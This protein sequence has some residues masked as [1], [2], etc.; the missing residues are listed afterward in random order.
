[1]LVTSQLPIQTTKI[2]D[3]LFDVHLCP[4]LWKRF[5]H[6]WKYLTVF[7]YLRHFCWLH[8]KMGPS[9]VRCNHTTW[10]LDDLWAASPWVQLVGLASPRF[11]VT[12]WNTGHIVELGQL[13]SL[14]SE[15]WLDIHSFTNL[16][17]AH[18]VVK[19]RAVNS[20]GKSNHV[21]TAACT[22]GT[23]P[24]PSL[25]RSTCWPPWAISVF[26]LHLLL[27]RILNI[28]PQVLCSQPLLKDSLSL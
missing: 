23:T 4:P 19:C 10:S 6:P 14:D 21:I 1:M 28:L 18:F 8:N 11:S 7:S 12:F 15:K 16:T 20:S 9:T 27:V 26:K 5:R 13:G 2:F 17:A 25:M 3:R 24:E 22:W